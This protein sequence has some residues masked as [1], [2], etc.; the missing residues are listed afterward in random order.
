MFVVN[1]ER[2]LRKNLPLQKCHLRR[3]C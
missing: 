3:L 2:G 1:T